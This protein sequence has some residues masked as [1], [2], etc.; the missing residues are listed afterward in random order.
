MLPAMIVIALILQR[1]LNSAVKK[2]QAESSARHGVLIE[3]LHLNQ[4]TVRAAGG[5]S[6]AKR[7]G[8]ICRR[9]RSLQ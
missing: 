5:S 6:D 9:N 7:L 3:L 1:P 2:M 4:I 8:K